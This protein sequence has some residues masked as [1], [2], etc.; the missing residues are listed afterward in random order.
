MSTSHHSSGGYKPS[1]YWYHLSQGEWVPPVSPSLLSL[2]PSF[3]I[4]LIMVP[5]TSRHGHCL[6]TFRTGLIRCLSLWRSRRSVWTSPSP[7]TS[8][9]LQCAAS[10]IRYWLVDWL[11][12]LIDCIAK[13]GRRRKWW[14]QHDRYLTSRSDN[15]CLAGYV[16]CRILN[17]HDITYPLIMWLCSTMPL[18]QVPFDWEWW[19]THV[20]ASVI[21]ASLGE[22]ICSRNELE[23]IPLYNPNTWSYTY[24]LSTSSLYYSI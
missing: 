17:I 19:I 13:G 12:W 2:L 15:R 18:Q 10:T 11:H 6:F 5:F 8:S 1:A 22:Y 21:M 20:F 9:T 3:T 16:S 7:C 24:L 14:L 4:E 23:D